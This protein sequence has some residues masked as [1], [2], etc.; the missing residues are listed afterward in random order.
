MLV[1]TGAN[2]FANMT[3]DK[4][5]APLDPHVQHRVATQK[6][7]ISDPLSLKVLFRQFLTWNSKAYLKLGVSDGSAGCQKHGMQP[8]ALSEHKFPCSTQK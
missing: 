2:L 6:H 7:Q 4:P 5:D 1:F 3:T 8:D